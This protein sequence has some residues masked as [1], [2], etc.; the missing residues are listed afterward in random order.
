MASMSLSI[1]NCLIQ[2]RARLQEEG[3]KLWLAPYYVDGIGAVDAELE[4]QIYHCIEIVVTCL[5]FVC[6][7]RIWP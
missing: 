1:E 4:V 6:S 3:V 2:V 5:H 7:C